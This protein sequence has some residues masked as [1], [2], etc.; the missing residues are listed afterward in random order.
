MENSEKETTVAERIKIIISKNNLTQTE[1]AQRL[2]ISPSMVSKLC[3]GSTEPS[4]RTIS[5][6]C[7]TFGI[8]ACW[9]ET[10]FGEMYSANAKD[11]LLAIFAGQTLGGTNH[12]IYREFMEVLADSS[13]SELY[14]ILRIARRLVVANEPHLEEFINISQKSPAN[15]KETPPAEEPEA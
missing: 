2:N 4:Y 5:D 3:S 12:P 15:Q 6:I 9:L 1:F 13:I 7:R 8:D 10:G 14:T 11:E